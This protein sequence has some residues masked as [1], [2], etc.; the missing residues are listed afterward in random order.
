MLIEH[1]E[2][3]S[4][5]PTCPLCQRKFQTE[6]EVMQHF[7][8]DHSSSE[9]NGTS[10]QRNTGRP[11]GHNSGRTSD[12]DR[13][14]AQLEA[15]LAKKG[16]KHKKKGVMRNV[17]TVGCSFEIS[18]QLNEN[19]DHCMA[20][21]KTQQEHWQRYK[22]VGESKTSERAMQER[23]ALERMTS[24]EVVGA[25]SSVDQ[26]PSELQLIEQTF[27]TNPPEVKLA[28]CKLLKTILSK[29][30]GIVN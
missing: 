3:N 29:R 1:H 28:S 12:R 26:A 9:S 27:N 30:M 19:M 2:L 17:S 7:Q 18:S 8:F 13:R 10:T 16:P 4:N 23:Q 22:A 20:C 21:L 14:A 5:K 15:R 25:M 6:F 11:S 24:P